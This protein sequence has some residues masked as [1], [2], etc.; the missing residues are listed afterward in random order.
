MEQEQVWHD[1]E[2]EPLSLPS[3]NMFKKLQL[4]ED[5]SE[6]HYEERLRRF[7]NSKYGLH[8]WAVEGEG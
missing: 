1:S 5:P 6:Q 3:R 8:N 2:E 7:Y 4:E